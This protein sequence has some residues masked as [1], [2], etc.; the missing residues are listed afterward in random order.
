[1]GDVCQIKFCQYNIF[2]KTQYKVMV[3]TQPICQ[4]ITCY[5]TIII[6]DIHFEGKLQ[7]WWPSISPAIQYK[8]LELMKICFNSF[9]KQV[10]SSRTMQLYDFKD[11]YFWGSV[12]LC[13]IL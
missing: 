1:M 6:S 10:S 13:K 11:K 8:I 2:M 12:K 9:H 7:I 3:E 5:L 4:I